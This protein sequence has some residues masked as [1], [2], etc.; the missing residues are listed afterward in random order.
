MPSAAAGTCVLLPVCL[1]DPIHPSRWSHKLM[2]RPLC[3]C[4]SGLQLC[5]LQRDLQADLRLHQR[6]V[7]HDRQVLL[8]HRHRRRTALVRVFRCS[9][10]AIKPNRALFHAL[11]SVPTKTPSGCLFWLPSWL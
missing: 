5:D 2:M 1:R 10:S 3:A 7:R 9:C 4:V 6:R 8:R 11:A